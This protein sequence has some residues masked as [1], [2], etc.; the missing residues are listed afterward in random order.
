MTQLFFCRNLVGNFSQEKSCVI[1]GL[2]KPQFKAKTCILLLNLQ[3]RSQHRC[4]RHKHWCWCCYC[5]CYQQQ[6]LP[7]PQKWTKTQTETFLMPLVVPVTSFW[8]WS[9]FS[10]HLAPPLLLLLK[11]L[12]NWS[13][14]MQW[15]FILHCENI[16]LEE[17]YITERTPYQN[18]T[19]IFKNIFCWT[20]ISFFW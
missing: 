8:V 1:S 19:N 15:S 6:L 12:N 3:Q 7:L 9:T 20:I 4:V 17:K 18:T 11:T 10:Q 13:D 5:C 2:I 14:C 16:F